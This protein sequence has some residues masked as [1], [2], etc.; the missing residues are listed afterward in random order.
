MAQPPRLPGDDFFC[1][2]FQMWYRLKDCLVRHAYETT[3]ECAECDQG[4]ANLEISGPPQ[5]LPRWTR[6]PAAN[7]SGKE[8]GSRR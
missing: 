7:G 6:L 2:K 3:H 1:W 8:G 5:S 4:A